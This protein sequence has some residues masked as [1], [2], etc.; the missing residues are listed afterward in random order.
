MR[1]CDRFGCTSLEPGGVEVCQ[2][3]RELRR[4][5]TL[6]WPRIN[7]DKHPGVSTP[8]QKR[9]VNIAV[10]VAA[11]L[12]GRRGGRSRT[13]PVLVPGLESFVTWRLVAHFAVVK[14]EVGAE[15]L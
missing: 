3:G 14:V 4:A 12:C 7:K 1:P 6:V 15:Q 13:R 10:S 9:H 8:H 2:R 11:S 5:V